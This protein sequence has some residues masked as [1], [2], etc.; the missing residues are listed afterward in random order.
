MDG[1][2]YKKCPNGHGVG[3]IVRD[4]VSDSSGRRYYVTRLRLF[5]FAVDLNQGTPHEGIEFATVEGTTL[6]ITCNLC[7]GKT[8]WYPG[9]EAINHLVKTRKKLYDLRI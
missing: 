1:I 7:L 5:R 9:E 8:A 2:K 6:E 4:E 3:R